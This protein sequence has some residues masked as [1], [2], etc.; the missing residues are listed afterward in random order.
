MKHVSL[1]TCKAGTMAVIIKCFLN[2]Q[3]QGEAEFRA[4]SWAGGGNES[5]GSS[6]GG[7]LIAVIVLSVI[8]IL[9]LGGVAV[10][11]MLYVRSVVLQ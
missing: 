1:T 8:L 10:V 5:D 2:R 4:E 3:L 11:Y 6:D 9:L 7:L